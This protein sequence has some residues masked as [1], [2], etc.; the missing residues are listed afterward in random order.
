MFE[1]SVDLVTS[2][3]ATGW[4]YDKE[5]GVTAD[6]V[7]YLHG[8]IIGSAPSSL[9]R[10]DLEKVGFGDG[11]CG[12]DLPFD[13][14]VSS[15]DLPFVSV[16]PRASNLSIPRTS[17]DSYIDL[18]A[19]LTRRHPGAGRSRTILGGLWT[20]RTDA[21]QLLAGRLAAGTC[22]ASVQ[23]HVR[24]LICDGF[25]VL[26]AEQSNGLPNRVYELLTQSAKAQVEPREE[27]LAV[28]A[29]H[30]VTD[31]LVD[32]LRAV[33]DDVPIAYAFQALSADDE[34]FGQ[35][36]R[37]ERFTSPAETVA[38]YLPT[39]GT[40]GRL[41]H[42][43]DSHEFPEFG[44]DGASRWSCES[45]SSL[46]IIATGQERPVESLDLSPD[47]ITIV[48]PGLI[49][50]VTCSKPG[51]VLRIVFAPKRNTPIRFLSGEGVWQEIALGDGV[52]VRIS[53]LSSSV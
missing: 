20:D 51:S 37:F 29:S 33:F 38:I 30:L 32:V 6:V 36:S 40:M 2:T 18:V 31:E 43:L 1:G 24:K 17:E 35:A 45:T 22:P 25:S 28:L 13:E 3:K 27:A 7:A 41:D 12:F 42:V 11:I 21:L 52:R 4:L 39:T 8:R 26:N 16:T 23:S 10:P 15:N 49:H 46:P 53:W 48:G 34:R 50:R 44:R 9:Y 14:A 5:A 47:R 19:R